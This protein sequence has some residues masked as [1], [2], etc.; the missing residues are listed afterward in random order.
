ML[1]YYQID[2]VFDFEYQDVIFIKPVGTIFEP[3]DYVKI[4]SIQLMDQILLIS[5]IKEYTF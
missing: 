2:E 1:Q 5:I 4:V 3:Y